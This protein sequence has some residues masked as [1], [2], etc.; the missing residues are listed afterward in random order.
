MKII[1]LIFTSLFFLYGPIINAQEEEEEKACLAPNKKAQKALDKA[2]S[3]SGDLLVISKLLS[4]AI[5]LDPENATPYFE[6]GL[7]AFESGSNYYQSDNTPSRGDRSFMKS[8]EMLEKAIQYC[9]DIHADAFY[10]LGVINLTQKD[11]KQ[12]LHWFEKFKSFEHEDNN[13]YPNDYNSKLKTIKN[14]LK[15]IESEINL[16]ENEVPFNPSIVKNVSSLN[17]E[18]FPILSPDNELIFYTRRLDRRNLGDLRSNIKEEFTKSERDDIYSLFDNGIPLE[19]PFNNGSMDS[20]GAA[21]LSVD[22]KEMI[23]TGCKYI[24]IQGQK[25]KNCDLYSTTFQRDDSGEIKWSELKNLGSQINTQDGWESQPTLSANGNTLYFTAVRPTTDMDDIFISQ[26]NDDGTWGQ[27]EPFIE[28]NTPGKDKSPFLHQDSE[29]LYFVSSVSEQ[30]K[31]IGG[32]D[33]FYTRKKQDGSWDTPINI[34]YPINTQ[35]DEIGIFVSTNGKEAFYSSR[36]G[37][38]WN[39]YSF[40]LYPKA[41]PKAVFIAKGTLETDNGE[42]ITDATIEVSYENEAQSETIRVNGNDGKY[43]VVVKADEPQDVMITVKKEGHTFDSKIIEREVVAQNKTV[44]NS[45]LAVRKI[46]VGKPYT[47]N[48]ILYNTASAELSNRSK[49][50]L[51]QF[52]KFLKEN[53]TIKITIQG[54]TDNEGDDNKN[55]ELS[56]KR[57]EG[58]KDYLTSLGI[59]QDRMKARGFGETQPKSPNT[60]ENNKAQNR[61]TDFVIENI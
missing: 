40:E 56:Q 61:R 44:K 3:G 17:D 13:R 39:I 59:K 34:G 36:Q 38:K 4:T 20:Y 31:G 18:Y 49:F 51:K 5:E 8:E 45:D 35:A 9:S 22:N 6:F 16:L 41:R 7:F 47:I 15:E 27:A 43:A 33:I 60:S 14:T 2:K 26:R 55:L 57:A 54:H 29:T 19:N 28:I 42:P 24:D 46:E 58:V 1:Y 23:V 12:A 21:T 48:D 37:G 10:Y 53:P 25:Y 52:A 30:R 11:K 50:V 32:T